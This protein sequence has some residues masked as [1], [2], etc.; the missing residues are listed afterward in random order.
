MGSPVNIEGPE[1]LFEKLPLALLKWI[2]GI[3]P[4]PEDEMRVHRYILL[5]VEFRLKI[6]PRN[7][8]LPL[9]LTPR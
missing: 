5:H 1:S 9:Y 8:G 3:Q 2:R 7:E 6:G 4:R